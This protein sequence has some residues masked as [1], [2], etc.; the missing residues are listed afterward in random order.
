MRQRR[1]VELLSD[2]ECEIRYHPGKA[3]IKE[4]QL[5]ALKPDNIANEALQRMDKNLEVKDDGARY[6]MNRI[7]TPRFSGYKDVI[8]NEAHKT[9]YSIHPGSDKM[10]LDPKKLYWCPNTKAE[11]ATYVRKCLTYVRV[12]VEYQ[13]PSGLLQQLE[14]PEWKWERVTMDFITKL[15]KTSGRLDTIWVIVDR[16]TK[17]PHFLSIK[18][19][20]KMEKLTRTYIREIVRIQGTPISIMSDRDSRFMS[21]FWQSLQ[22]ALGTKLDMSTAYHPQTNGQSERTIQTLED[23]LRACVI[24]FG[25]AW[26]THLGG[27]HSTGQRTSTQ[28]YTY[29]SRDHTRDNG[30]NRSSPR[31]DRSGGLQTPTTTKT[32]QRPSYLPRIQLEEVSIDETL[33]ILLYDIE[34][35]ENL[36]FV[37]EPVEIMDREVKTKSHTNSQGPLERQAWT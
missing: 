20:D 26:D 7:W 35:N 6:L 4:A 36:H 14:I 32:Q 22:K 24:D 11:I 1:W 2:Y 19:T 9:I 27:G 17:S 25:K 23:M 10:Y 33:V 18:E 3:N 5:E 13:K 30:E 37:E 15:P 21:R 12:K 29:R 28:Q 16:L 8:M 31:T 34:V